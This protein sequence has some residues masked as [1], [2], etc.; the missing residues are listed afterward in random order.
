MHLHTGRGEKW[1][2][3]GLEKGRAHWNATFGGFEG[4]KCLLVAARS[5][6]RFFTADQNAAKGSL[7]FRHDPI[8]C[9]WRGTVDP[10]GAQVGGSQ[11][12]PA[13]G[14]ADDRHWVKWTKILSRSMPSIAHLS[15]SSHATSWGWAR[16]AEMDCS[17]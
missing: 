9:V 8:S 3:S 15:R 16:E 7:W 1:S 12:G 14:I 4:D 10:N 5:D 11:Q 2:G 6:Q 17:G 13:S